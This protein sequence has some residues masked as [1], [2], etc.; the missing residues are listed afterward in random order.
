MTKF[1]LGPL[2]GQTLS[3]LRSPL[4]LR[5]TITSGGKIDALDALDDY[6]KRDERLTAYRLVKDEGMIHFLFSEGRGGRRGM[7]CACATY[8]V[9]AN[10]PS[11]AVM[12]NQDAWRQWCREQQ[13]KGD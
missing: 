10:Q 13:A 9:V 3:L 6:P 2:G 7:W 12:R 4:F 5:A 8:E 1:I 11:D